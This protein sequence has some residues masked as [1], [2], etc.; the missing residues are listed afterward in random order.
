VELHDLL[1]GLGI[2][3]GLL[4][5]VTVILPGTAIVIASV[6]IW[7]IVESSPGGWLAAGLVTLVGL[8]GMAVRFLI[9]GRRL[10]EHGIPMSSLL[11]A[12]LVA[13]IGFFVIPVIG[14]LIGFVGTI[15]LLE[16]RRVGEEQ[17]WGSSVQGIKAVA[18]SIGIELVAGF[19]MA[20]I[21]LVAVIL[22]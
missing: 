8:V 3:I 10:K 19:L 20:G 18:L 5:I 4:A 14:A 12:L 16:V 17:A 13:T 11:I 21:W 22:G 15:Y 2:L 9:P 1:A 6:W 7:A